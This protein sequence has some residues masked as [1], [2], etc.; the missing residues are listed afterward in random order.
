MAAPIKMNNGMV[1]SVKLSSSLKIVSAI[2]PRLE[3]G[4]KKN[5]ITTAD[6]PSAKAIGMP[7]NSSTKVSAP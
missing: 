7:E 4:M 3:A 6:E 2:N 5:M 1:S